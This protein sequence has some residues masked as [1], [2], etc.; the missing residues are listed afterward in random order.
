MECKM[1]NFRSAVLIS[2]L[3]PAATNTFSADFPKAPAIQKE[4]EAQGLQRANIEELKKFIPGII[5]NEGVKGVEHTLTFKA[6][7]TVDR[8]GFND[9]KGEWHFDE[10]NNAYCTGFY[11]KK[12][13]RENCFAVYRATD[14]TN[15]FDYEI[16]SGFY[17]HVWH[18][19]E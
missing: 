6:D 15:F 16:G 17:K 2:L 5:N 19:A 1:L 4:A 8:T 12:G 11:K 10:K 7:G 14:G 3:I 13:Y 9:L 18:P